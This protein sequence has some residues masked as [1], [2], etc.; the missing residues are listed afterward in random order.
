MEQELTCIKCPMGCRLVVTEKQG[1]LAVCGN[2][3]P[4]GEEYGIS[5]V[6]NPTRT[7]TGTVKILNGEIRRLPIK[8]LKEVPKNAV[9]PIASE[10]KKICVT[11]PVCVGDTVADN[12]ANTGVSIVAT[13]TVERKD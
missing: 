3:C 1:K 13:R 10:L 4:R 2:T 6:T 9:L 11:A 5:E 8:T 12:I 7:V